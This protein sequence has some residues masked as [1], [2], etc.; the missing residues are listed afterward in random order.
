MTEEDKMMLEQDKT[1][2][3]LGVPYTIINGDKGKDAALENVIGY[4]DHTIKTC[5]IDTPLK[6]SNSVADL[7]TYRKQVIRH[8]LIHAFL[9]ESGLGY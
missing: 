8:E 2:D 9:F 1:V 4:C 6:T 7:E 5:V 3:V